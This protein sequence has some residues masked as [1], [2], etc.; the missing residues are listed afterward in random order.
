MFLVEQIIFR[1]K[2]VFELEDVLKILLYIRVLN[3]YFWV[4]VD[5]DVFVGVKF[6]VGVS[7]E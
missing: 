2:M 4:S 6:L 1:F 7:C 3:C 5:P